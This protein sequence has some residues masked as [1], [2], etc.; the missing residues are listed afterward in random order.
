MRFLK[1][2]FQMRAIHFRYSCYYIVVVAVVVV[3]VAFA[4]IDR[5]T[6]YIIRIIMLV[7]K[8]SKQLF[9]FRSQGRNIEQF[10][11][12]LGLLLFLL[13]LRLL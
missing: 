2:L 11:L 6:I 4:V 1:L 10:L 7:N 3:V 5:I 13:L 12:L 8:V 9:R